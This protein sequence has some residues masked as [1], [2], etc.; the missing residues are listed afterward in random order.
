MLTHKS[1]LCLTLFLLL[2]LVSCDDD[3]VIMPASLC[4]V[5]C[6]D[7][8]TGDTYGIAL[9]AIAWNDEDD[10]YDKYE[11]WGSTCN[12]YIDA[13]SGQIDESGEFITTPISIETDSASKYDED[14][15]LTFFEVTGEGFTSDD[16]NALFM[17]ED[18]AFYQ[19]LDESIIEITQ[20][21]TSIA[22]AYQH[23]INPCVMDA[24]LEV[25]V[26]CN[27]D[28][29]AEDREKDY[30]RIIC[31]DLNDG[32]DPIDEANNDGQNIQCED[33]KVDEDCLDENYEINEDDIETSHPDLYAIL[34]EMKEALS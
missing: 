17:F 28:E 25:N 18:I 26:Y 23:S 7:D 33:N 29:T 5:T 22:A 34:E 2:F 8:A 20:T 12:V 27:S 9:R 21:D 15:T 10:D 19:L 24:M 4:Q 16:S 3:I 32:K 11:G 31:D 1:S 14:Y 6:T 30:V 13:Y